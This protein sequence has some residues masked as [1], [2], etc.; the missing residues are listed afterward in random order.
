MEKSL[1]TSHGKIILIGEHS[2]V[3]KKPAI[4]IPLNSVSLDVNIEEDNK[5]RISCKFYEGVLSESSEDLQGI[6]TLI[7]TFLHEYKIE[8]NIKVTIASDIPNERGMGSSAAA[9]IGVAKALFR[10]FKIS[11]TNEDIM[12]WANI[13]EKIIHGNPSGIDINVIMNNKS[14]YFVKDE[15]LEL[16]PINLGAYLVIGDTGIKGKTK[17]A[18]MNVKRLI[19]LDHKYMDYIDEL[20]K[21]ANEAKIYIENKQL[22]EL[23]NTMTK[24]HKYLQKIEV[25]STQLDEMVNIALDNDA[26]GAKLT[27]GGRGGCMIA[28][29]ETY[30][31]ANDIKNKYRE[32]GKDVWISKL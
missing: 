9:S 26:L 30:E 13:S 3:Y 6:R 8:K 29:C 21:L 1:S 24:A 5:N 14:V 17:D 4:A 7:E 2:V 27:G 15:K 20:E 19:D 32:L 23:G 12:K 22:M 25:S 28:L 10:F 18:V 31:I 16:F 11:H